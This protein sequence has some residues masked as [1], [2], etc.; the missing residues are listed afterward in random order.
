[1]SLYCEIVVNFRLYSHPSYTSVIRG[2]VDIVD[3]FKCVATIFDRDLILIPTSSCHEE[4]NSASSFSGSCCL[5][6]SSWDFISHDYSHINCVLSFSF[7][8]FY[9]DLLEM[10]KNSLNLI[11]S[12]LLHS[13]CKVREGLPTGTQLSSY[14][15]VFLWRSLL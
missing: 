5:S 8:C 2:K 14:C 15:Y 13:Y 3:T 10:E 7:I 6:G 1:M 11:V 4:F 12:N 9:N